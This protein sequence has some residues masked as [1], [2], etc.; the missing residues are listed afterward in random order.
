MILLKD[1]MASR[2]NVDS[3]I[4]KKPSR[5]LQNCLSIAEYG[6]GVI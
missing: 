1:R 5:L 3:Y 4:K 2:D 6:P